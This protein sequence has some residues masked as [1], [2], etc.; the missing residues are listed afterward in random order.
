[1]FWKISVSDR[2]I[3]AR[4]SDIKVV[5]VRLNTLKPYVLNALVSNCNILE[6]RGESVFL[7]L[8]RFLAQMTV[9]IRT[10]LTSLRCEGGQ[11]VIE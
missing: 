10:N 6:L 11:L 7:D 8:D 1:M 5:G 9:P 2:K 3:V 4:L